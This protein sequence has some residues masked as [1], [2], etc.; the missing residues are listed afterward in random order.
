MYYKLYLKL[1]S[2][3]RIETSLGI[4]FLY[5]TFVSFLLF[6]SVSSR[7][8]VFGSPESCYILQKKAI[9]NKVV[10]EKGD[11]DLS[12]FPITSETVLNE[13]HTKMEKKTSG[14]NLILSY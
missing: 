4:F 7:N 6:S 9:F 13:V 12:C 1:S 3:F 5:S 14:K 2:S 10:L 11:P 8:N